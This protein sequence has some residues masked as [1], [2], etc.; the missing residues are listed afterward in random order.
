MNSHMEVFSFF[1]SYVQGIRVKSYKTLWEGCKSNK[2]RAEKLMDLL[3]ERGLEG[4][5]TLD[6][7][8]KLRKRYEREKE[9]AE[10]NT[11]NIICTEGD[12]ETVDLFRSTS[13]KRP[14]GC[15]VTL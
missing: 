15:Y 6:D 8:R 10:L 13:L 11:S 4:K 5:P 14:F 1:L 2:A 7:C 9:V 12:Y 3:R